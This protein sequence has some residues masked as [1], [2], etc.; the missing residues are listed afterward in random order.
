MS[1]MNESFKTYLLNFPSLINCN[2]IDLYSLWPE[3]ALIS[4]AQ[5]QI[6]ANILDLVEHKNDIV[7]MFSVKHKSVE[8]ISKI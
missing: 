2:T 6:A 1:H 7:Q 4:V 5:L 3:D 8:T